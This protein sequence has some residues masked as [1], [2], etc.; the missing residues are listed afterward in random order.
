MTLKTLKLNLMT[1][2]KPCHWMPQFL[3]LRWVFAG[4]PCL[5]LHWNWIEI[6]FKS[7]MSTTKN[8]ILKALTPSEAVSTLSPC[9]RH[10]LRQ[11]LFLRSPQAAPE[12][13][14]ENHFS[15]YS[16]LWSTIYFGPQYIMKILWKKS[17]SHQSSVCSRNL[18]RKQ[19]EHISWTSIISSS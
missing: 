11:M 18:V 12:T 19:F 10:S 8:T 3:V 1:T 17:F 4:F 7:K 5:K 13:Q 6:E 2:L 15:I 14:W 16:G 9:Q